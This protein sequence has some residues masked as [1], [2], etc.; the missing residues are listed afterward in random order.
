MRMR[1]PILMLGLVLGLAA[2]VQ[3]ARIADLTHLGGDAP[4]EIQGFG[5]VVGLKGTG[6]GGDYLAAMQPLAK[7]L[8][9]MGDPVAVGKEL[10]SSNNVAIVML[11]VALPPQGV[12]V[13]Q[14]L[15]VKVSSVGAAK[16]LK[17]GRLIMAPMTFM[18]AANK[19]I[20]ALASGDLTL[21]DETMPTQATIRAGVRGG[22]TMQTDVTMENVD[23]QGS[24]ELV[25]SPGAAGFANATAIA[26]QI[27]EEVSPQTD[28]KAVA[29]AVDATTIRVQIPKAEQ[30]KPAGFI[31]RIQ[32][33]PVPTLPQVARI[34][35][36]SKTKTIVFS[37]DVELAPTIL[38]QG[39]LTITVAGGGAGGAANPPGSQV[40]FVGLD[41]SKQGG[42]KFKDLIESFNLLKVSPEDRISIIKQ[43]HD[44]GALRCQLD[45]D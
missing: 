13:N 10:K 14:K 31:A 18:M 26:D 19:G 33:L 43:L 21:D 35:I 23:T 6:D 12:R 8:T 25:L 2:S 5:L 16:S 1:M 24:F 4:N 3:G 44:S 42:A 17:G 15:D 41:P 22:A 32:Q 11:S 9:K 30:S 40:P 29:T 36:N 20:V 37:G 39:G 28:G 38:S 34:A 7:L 27:N 45:V